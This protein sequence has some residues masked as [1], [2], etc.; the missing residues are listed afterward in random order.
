MLDDCFSG[1]ASLWEAL[2]F[3]PFFVILNSKIVRELPGVRKSGNGDAGPG[4]FSG[5]NIARPVEYLITVPL[6]LYVEI[7][8][9][10]RAAILAPASFSAALLETTR[11][12]ILSQRRNHSQW[13]QP[14]PS[15]MRRA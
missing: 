5:G 4:P 7:R 3:H 2:A 8:S 15:L 9:S 11:S 13:Q 6:L 12:V 14:L 10:G 1:E